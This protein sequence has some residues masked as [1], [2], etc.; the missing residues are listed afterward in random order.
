MRILSVHNRYQ[1]RGGEDQVFESESSL[2]ERYG[3]QV[4]RL[5]FTNDTIPANP[6]LAQQLRLAAST[7]WSPASADRVREQLRGWK[8]DVVHFTNTFPIASP[9]VY[10]AAKGEGATVVQTVQ[11][12]RLICPSANLYRNGDICEECVGRAIP[13]PGIVHACYRGSRKETAVVTAMITAHRLRGTWH[14]DIDAYIAATNTS[15]DKLIEGGLPAEKTHVKP[16]FVNPR[17]AVT[18]RDEN[19]F[20][21]AGRLVPEK[22]IHTLIAAAQQLPCSI[23]IRVAGNGPLT[24]DVI[25]VGS[26]IVPIGSLKPER[27]AD[28]MGRTQALLFPSE[29]YEPFGLVAIEAF[30][31]STPVIAARTGGIPEI[32]QHGRTGL[33]FDPGSADDLAAKILWAIEHPEELRRMGENA[34]KEYEAKY[35]PERNYRMLMHIYEQAIDQTRHC[36]R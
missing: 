26:P 3:H 14:N 33:L 9:A 24:P 6:G 32:V 12:Y 1:Q 2:L 31:I 18:P 10:A 13:W 23:S 15:R 21:F 16:N 11:N 19:T 25:A 17:V 22:G 27:L 7:I 29:W 36:R 4:R 30:S 20:L 5:E 28:E 35:S 8:A 34:Q